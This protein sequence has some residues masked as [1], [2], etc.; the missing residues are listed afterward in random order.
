MVA[1]G[2]LLDT[3][4]KAIQGSVAGVDMKVDGLQSKVDKLDTQMRG[5]AAVTKKVDDLEVS[6]NFL[7]RE[8]ADMKEKLELR[9]KENKHIRERLEKIEREEKTVHSQMQQRLDDSERY[10]RQYSLRIKGVQDLRETRDYNKK[11]AQILTE[12][13]L[14]PYQSLEDNLKT[15]E[16]AHPLG[17]V[18]QNKEDRGLLIARFFN[19]THRNMVVQKAKTSINKASSGTKLRVVEDMIKVDYELKRKAYKQMQE[20]YNQGKKTRFYRGK[21]YIDGAVHRKTV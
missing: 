1:F 13:N 19:R 14:G 21:L 6:T 5:F 2:N 12:N 7:H 4:M 3:K 18:P 17:T 11:V 8:L 20:A 16:V 10:S 9:E 15:I